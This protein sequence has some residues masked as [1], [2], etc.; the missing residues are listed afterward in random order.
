MEN[1]ISKEQAGSD[2][3]FEGEKSFILINA[4]QLYNIIDGN[5]GEYELRLEI[6]SNAFTFNSFTFG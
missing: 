3:L 5:Y 6:K 2:I 4:P 1:I